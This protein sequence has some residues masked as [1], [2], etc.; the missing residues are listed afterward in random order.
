MSD[1][2]HVEHESMSTPTGYLYARPLNE[3]DYRALKSMIEPHF[4]GMLINAVS[5]I[6]NWPPTDGINI[7]S[8]AEFTQSNVYYYW[9]DKGRPYA[10]SG[11]LWNDRERCRAPLAVAE[12]ADRIADAMEAGDEDVTWLIGT[13]AS[14]LHWE[15]EEAAADCIQAMRDLA[16]ACRFAAGKGATEVT[17][18]IEV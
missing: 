6:P 7:G 5:G 18:H 9:I 15:A 2:F 12:A 17:V 11:F 13:V 4:L 3:E 10:E 14:R 8:M 1:L 16:K